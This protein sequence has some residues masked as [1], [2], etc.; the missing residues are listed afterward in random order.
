MKKH[1]F[2]ITSAINT[3]FGSYDPDQRLLQTFDTFNSIKERVPDAKI[4]IIESSGYKLEEEKLNI[5]QE[6]TDCVVNMSGDPAIKNY[7]N[8]TD[9]W[10][11]V[12]NMCEIMCFGAGLQLLDEKTTFLKECDFMHKLSGRYVL[13]DDFNL[14]HYEQYP[15]KIIVHEKMQSQ[16][17]P[18]F[19]G[20]PYQYP[21]MLYSWSVKQLDV[22]K[23][24]YKKATDE[25][26]ERLSQGKYADIEH[27][28][29]K[30]FPVESVQEV[31]MIGVM[32]RLGQNRVQV[33]R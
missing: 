19:V 22:I 17:D 9:N 15:D 26:G 10:D 21:S 20:I 33:F 31:P 5:L 18:N 29:F 4:I 16:F 30:H 11:I 3:K 13:T 12:K 28:M 1:L 7:Y 8:G 23:D 2:I 24:F 6:K 25:L 14:N 32:G 27:L